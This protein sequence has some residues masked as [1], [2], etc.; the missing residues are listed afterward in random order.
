MISFFSSL[1]VFALCVCTCNEDHCYLDVGLLGV[2]ICWT[3]M[4]SCFDQYFVF[5]M[6]IFC[7]DPDSNSLV[8]KFLNSIHITHLH[9]CSKDLLN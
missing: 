9:A 6:P 4:F 5:F 2:C 1:N 3:G 7:F 8:I